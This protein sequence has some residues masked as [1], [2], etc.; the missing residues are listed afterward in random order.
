M[1]RLSPCRRTSAFTLFEI[2]IVMSIMMLIV[3][4]GYASFSFFEDEDPFEK[5]VQQLTQMSKFSLNTAVIQHR[6]M[7]IAFSEEGFG[8]VGSTATGMSNFTVPKNVQIL[9]KRWQG[10]GWEKAEG[11]VWRFGE[12]GICEPLKVRFEIKNG[13]SREVTYHALTGGTMD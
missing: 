7:L 2:I 9:I 4:I 12:Q 6:G 5:P 8:V 13:G 11:Q 1:K 3:G 10:K